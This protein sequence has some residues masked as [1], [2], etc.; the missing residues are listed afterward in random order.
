[1]VLMKR[2]CSICGKTKL[3]D[4][5]GHCK[6]CAKK[7]EKRREE[8]RKEG[9]YDNMKKLMQPRYFNFLRDDK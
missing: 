2:Y 8:L 7:L 6:P 5:A 3:C 9:F 1:M 4:K